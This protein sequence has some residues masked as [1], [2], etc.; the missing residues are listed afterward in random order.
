M[1]LRIESDESGVRRKCGS[2]LLSRFGRVH[3]DDKDRAHRCPEYD[4]WV[5]I[6]GGSARTWCPSPR[7]VNCRRYSNSWCERETSRKWVLDATPWG[8]T[9]MYSR[10]RSS[11][12]M[13]SD[14]GIEQ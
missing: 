7:T 1:D 12:P 3:G 9:R 8:P 2:H 14:C 5:R 13:Y 4:S 10:S 11:T 6:C